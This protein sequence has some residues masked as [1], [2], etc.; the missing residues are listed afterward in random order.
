MY[1]CSTIS[2]TSNNYKSLMEMKKQ[3]FPFSLSDVISNA[4]FLS[5]LINDQNF[6]IFLG[7]G[8]SGFELSFTNVNILETCF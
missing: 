3:L 5:D 7:L 1:R 6:I 8:V 4:S 2:P